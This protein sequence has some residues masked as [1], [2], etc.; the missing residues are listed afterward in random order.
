MAD[1]LG[2]TFCASDL[3]GEQRVAVQRDDRTFSQ[4][5]RY[6]QLTHV[7]VCGK[8][9]ARRARQ[10]ADLLQHLEVRVRVRE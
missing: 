8:S 3:G 2:E 5:L 4:G 10:R 6:R 9:T 7:D 1:V